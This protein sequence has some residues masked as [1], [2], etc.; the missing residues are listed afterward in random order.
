[1]KRIL[2]QQPTVDRS[3]QSPPATIVLVFVDGF[4]WGQ[5]DAGRNPFLQYGGEFFPCL[6]DGF[7]AEH[8]FLCLPDGGLGKPIDVTLGVHGTPQS[9][10]GQT[11]LLT[12]VNAQGELGYHLTGFP[13]PCLREILLE[14]SVIKQ[15][16]NQGLRAQFLNVFRPR[17]FELTREQQLRSSATTLANLAA[18]L[19]FHTLDDIRQ[20]CAI[21]Q[22]FTNQSLRERGFDVPLF[23]PDEAGRILAHEARTYD[24]TLF[25]YFQ[26]D[27]IGHAQDAAAAVTELRKLDEFL[28]ALLAEL[29]HGETGSDQ[30]SG[31]D[32]S[33]KPLVI[34]TSDHGN[35]EDLSTKRHTGN[36]V[37]LLAWG[38]G[39]DEFLAAVPD[40]A[41][42]TPAI[43]DRL[44]RWSS[45]PRPR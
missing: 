44:S 30:S 18:D 12:G 17:W 28:A 19:P 29:F 35:L 42:V 39:A 37:P 25:E 40:L 14:R 11:S 15:V 16:D 36:P 32:E 23:T 8:D 27:R 5:A 7:A 3:D 26:T 31:G 22:E 38:T 34:L 45:P 33:A 13:N 2:P 4:G 1:M 43:L 6:V 9:A 41:G 10:T 21:Y 24:F 20:Q